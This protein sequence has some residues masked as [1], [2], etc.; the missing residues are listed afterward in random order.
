MG[1]IVYEIQKCPS[2]SYEN[3]VCVETG[4]K[5]SLLPEIEHFAKHR[6]IVR[7]L[8]PISLER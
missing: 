7:I 8:A 2:L 4:F 3:E 5:E 1:M 6:G